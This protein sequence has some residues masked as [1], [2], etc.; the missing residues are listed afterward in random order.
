[1]FPLHG[2]YFAFI[3]WLC[4]LLDLN[5]F[6]C[7]VYT[8]IVLLQFL[9]PKSKDD[10][11]QIHFKMIE[12]MRKWRAEKC[13][14]LCPVS[15]S[16]AALC[17]SRKQWSNCNYIVIVRCFACLIRLSILLSS[18]LIVHT[19]SQ[20]LVNFFFNIL[21]CLVFFALLFF[22]HFVSVCRFSLIVTTRM[23]LRDRVNRD[24]CPCH[25][26]SHAFLVK[27]RMD[28]WWEPFGL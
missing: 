20:P 22:S 24:T 18:H 16:L 21:F 7:D 12:N 4:G 5:R 19:T 15:C 27:G 1:M 17:Q 23:L 28:G 6:E 9:G 26:F 14:V 11:H 25:T 13:C 2:D 10:D 8:I 3:I